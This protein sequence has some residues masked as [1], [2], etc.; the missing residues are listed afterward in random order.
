MIQG[1]EDLPRSEQKELNIERAVE[2]QKLAA[3]K[4]SQQYFTNG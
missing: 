2:K 1:V 4:K 3:Q